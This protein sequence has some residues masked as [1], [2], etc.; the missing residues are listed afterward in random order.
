[1]NTVRNET[2]SFWRKFIFVKSKKQKNLKVLSQQFKQLKQENN[3]L[4]ANYCFEIP[5]RLQIDID[6]FIQ[7]Q[8]YKANNLNDDGLY[9]MIRFLSKEPETK[10]EYKQEIL[11]LEEQNRIISFNK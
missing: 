7:T 11:K 6:I 5:Q 8:M 1:M 4:K 9:K 2:V 3:K 10:K